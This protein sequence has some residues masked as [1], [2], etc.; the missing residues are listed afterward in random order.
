MSVPFENLD[1]HLG[2]KIL[3]DEKRFYDKIVN[4]KRGGFC[5]EL[6]GLFAWL[7]REMGFEATLH[8]GR[9]FQDGKPGPE[10]DH[11][12]LIV[13]LEEPWLAD[14]GFGD[15]FIE[16]LRLNESGDQIQYGTAYRI[17]RDG[18]QITLLRKKSG[19]S[20]EPQYIFRTKPHLLSEFAEMCTYHQTSPQSHFT[21]KRVCSLATPEGRITLS[22][23]RIIHHANGKR[24]ERDLSK[25]EYHAALEEYFGVVLDSSASFVSPHSV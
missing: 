3:L 15:S 4:R 8:S 23:N 24:T 25:A 5:Y 11:L 17:L 10:F 2:N 22:D 6:N 7:L 21:R 20:E 13:H 1:I 16:P 12:T 14:V 9:V 18:E 19:G